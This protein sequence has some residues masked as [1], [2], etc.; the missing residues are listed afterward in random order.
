VTVS[1]GCVL[2]QYNQHQ[3]SYLFLSRDDACY[4]D[5]RLIGQIIS[6]LCCFGKLDSFVKAHLL[7]CFCYSLYGCEL[8]DFDSSSL[9]GFCAA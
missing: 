9:D 3:L 6:V 5:G 1:Y 8:W 2:K 7:K 4:S